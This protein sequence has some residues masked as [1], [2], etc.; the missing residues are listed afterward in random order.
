MFGSG[1]WRVD[2][3]TG[4]ATTLLPTEAG[5]GAYNLA[6][7]PY[8]AP[9]GDLYFFYNVALSPD[10]MIDRAPLQMVRSSI[11]GV[12]ARTVLRPETFN[13]LNEALWAPDASFVLIADAPIEGVREGGI[14]ELY[15]SNGDPGP[16]SLLEF[17][18]DL[19]W[20]P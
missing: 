2:A 12:T 1:L 5:G 11:D 10:G 15:Y 20:G 8:A 7:Y 14:I 13:M 3:N 17:A 6:A 16:V 9:D 4:N 18:F 19:K